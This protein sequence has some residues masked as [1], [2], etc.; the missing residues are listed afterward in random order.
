MLASEGTP[1]GTARAIDR[2]AEHA[3]IGTRE[4][5]VVEHAASELTPR[6]REDRAFA[7]SVDRGELARLN[8]AFHRGADDVERARLGGEY[9]RV[10]KSTEHERSPPARI[11]RGKHRVADR[12]D[13]AEGALDVAQRVGEA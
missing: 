11:T 10:A 2:A 6:Q 8:L 7:V 12:D 4:I 5:D 13:E 3:T 9:R 1:K